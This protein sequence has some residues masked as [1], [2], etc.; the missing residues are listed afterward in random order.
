MHPWWTRP[1]ERRRGRVR[2]LARRGGVGT[3]PRRRRPYG[4]RERGRLVEVA[5]PE[6]FHEVAPREDLDVVHDAR[7]GFE[8]GDYEPLERALLP[9]FAQPA[10]VVLV[11]GAP[12]LGLD[13]G[14]LPDEEIDLQAL[15]R[16]PVGERL[17][18]AHGV[19][20]AAQLVVDP[21]LEG[22]AVLGRPRGEAAAALEDPGHAVVEEVELRRR[23]GLPLPRR[24]PRR[25]LR[26]EERVLQDAE[27]F[28][29][30][31]AGDLRIPRDL[32]EI[33]L[34]PVAER[35]DL[36]EPTERRQVPRRALGRDF[37]AEVD[38]DVVPQVL[39]R[40]V[41]EPE[42]RQESD[43]QRA[44]EREA[45]AELGRRERMQMQL[46]GAPA[47]QVHAPAT[48]LAGARA[49]EQE[50]EPPLLDEA[51]DLVEQPGRL[52]DFVDHDG[53]AV[54]AG[55]SEVFRAACQPRERLGG[56]KVEDPRAGEGPLEQPRL[57][58]LARAE[59]KARLA[60]KRRGEIEVAGNVHGESFRLGTHRNLAS[61]LSRVK[62]NRQLGRR[63]SVI[64]AGS[65]GGGFV[66]TSDD[67]GEFVAQLLHSGRTG[68]GYDTRRSRRFSPDFGASRDDKNPGDP[69]KNEIPFSSHPSVCALR[70]SE[71]DEAV[72]V[73]FDMNRGVLILR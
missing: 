2:G 71:C 46:A 12:R 21:V 53:G 69:P 25:K 45:L 68:V 62:E 47:E 49:R 23:D 15:L 40:L 55:L 14:L 54:R 66:L 4:P 1:Q 7:T 36:E 41:R 60:R 61:F 32:G 42:P 30:R 13:G 50:P 56:Q 52:L 51:V 28:L 26:G 29:H 48:Q 5:G 8:A 11:D 43:V 59:E 70:R 24:P 10:Q 20:A 9:Q 67:G 44:V 37:L 31:A 17:A 73:R 64:F 22:V 16:P 35:G 39:L 65:F 27:V 72:S 57:A 34:L 63:F 3:P 18:A 38:A 33:E 19:E 6:A 58:A